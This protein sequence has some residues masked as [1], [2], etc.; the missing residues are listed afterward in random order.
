MTRHKKII[1]NGQ[2]GQINAGFSPNGGGG[3]L[4]MG[5]NGPQVIEKDYHNQDV[6]RALEKL[7]GNHEFDYDKQAWRRWYV[8]KQ[9]REHIN[10]RRDE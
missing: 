5:G 7:T 8:D 1:Q 4:Q 2:P 6:L 10:S 9:M 3:G